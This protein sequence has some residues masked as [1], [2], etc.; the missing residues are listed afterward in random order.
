M[1]DPKLMTEN[2]DPGPQPHNSAAGSPTKRDTSR[3]GPQYDLV[4]ITIVGR[5]GAGVCANASTNRSPP[6][7]GTKR[8]T[9]RK[10]R[11]GSGDG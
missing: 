3:L 9:K 6:F 1:V 4:P 7:A 10:R 2:R 8:P 5:G 11:T